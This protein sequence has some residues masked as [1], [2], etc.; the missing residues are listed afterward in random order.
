M[1]S[2]L[3]LLTLT[4]ALA[5]VGASLRP[6]RADDVPPVVRISSTL[7]RASDRVGQLSVTADVANGF[8]IYALTQPRPFLATRITVTGARAVRVN[9]PFTPSRP[10]KVAKHPT[11]GV[12]LQVLDGLF[13][14]PEPIVQA[15]RKTGPTGTRRKV[16]LRG[17]DNQANSKELVGEARHYTLNPRTIVA[18]HDIS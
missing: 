17:G 2:S 5:L 4:F 16:S 6:A 7:T 8:H 14:S 13:T 10:P 12:E 15:L 3:R 1:R 18:G 11:L 9:G